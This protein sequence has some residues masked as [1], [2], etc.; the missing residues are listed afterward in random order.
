MEG[1]DGFIT[2][3]GQVIMAETEEKNGNGGPK[4]KRKQYE[5]ELRRL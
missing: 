4:L 1:D 3:W 2:K 5:K